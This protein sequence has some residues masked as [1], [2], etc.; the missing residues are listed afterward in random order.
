MKV[1]CM[2]EDGDEYW[3]AP[4]LE[5]AKAVYVEITG[6]LPDSVEEVSEEGLDKLIVID[7]DENEVPTG[8]KFTFRE[9]LQQR[10]AEGVQKPEF[11]AGS[12]W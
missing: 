11:F 12:N 1:Y 9:Y 6:E 5:A 7:T 2:D 8:K 4:S 3:L 10:I